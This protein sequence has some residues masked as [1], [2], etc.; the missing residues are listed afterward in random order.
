MGGGGKEQ[1]SC[2]N[3]KNVLILNLKKKKKESKKFLLSFRGTLSVFSPER[4]MGSN[5][6]TP[7]LELNIILTLGR[8][9]ALLKINLRG[10]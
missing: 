1:K 8:Y 7:R 5:K 3:R 9:S 10:T 4:G 2:I 6:E